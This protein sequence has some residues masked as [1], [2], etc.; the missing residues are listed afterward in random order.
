MKSVFA[1]KC[2]N[3]TARFQMRVMM[4]LAIVY[5]YGS[6]RYIRMVF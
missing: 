5:Y 1:E 2:L 6:E 3:L 4:R